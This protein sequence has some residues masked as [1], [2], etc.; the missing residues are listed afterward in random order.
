MAHNFC[1]NQII[2][3]YCLWVERITHIM[4]VLLTS[5]KNKD[6]GI[7]FLIAMIARLKENIS[8]YVVEIE[9]KHENAINLSNS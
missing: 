6:S 1:S 9:A 8:S 2:L 4:Q 7:Y 5:F 3:I